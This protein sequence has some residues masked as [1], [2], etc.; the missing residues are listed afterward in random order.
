ML[1][2]ELPNLVIPEKL[3][4]TSWDEKSFWLTEGF[5]FSQVFSEAD[6]NQLS[7]FMLIDARLSFLLSLLDSQQPTMTRGL[8]PLAGIVL[9]L[10]S[11]AELDC[12]SD[13]EKYWSEYSGKPLPQ[14]AGSSFTQLA[15]LTEISENELQKLAPHC[16]LYLAGFENQPAVPAGFRIENICKFEEDSELG[17][18]VVLKLVR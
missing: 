16:T 18:F 12:D 3:L 2:P 9:A 17:T 15:A 5:S 13:L 10:R 7:P 4:V 11:Q 1:N 6:E 8:P 14:K